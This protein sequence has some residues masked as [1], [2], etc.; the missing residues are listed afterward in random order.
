MQFDGAVAV[1]GL[2]A[3]NELVIVHGGHIA[4]G[5]AKSYFGVYFAN[6]KPALYSGFTA[7]STAAVTGSVT[8]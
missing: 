6:A 4:S 3:V 1:D 8:S 5:A 2:I 7:A